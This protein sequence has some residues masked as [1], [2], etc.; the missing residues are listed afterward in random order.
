MGLFGLVYLLAIPNQNN[1]GMRS[2]SLLR[3]KC[4]IVRESNLLRRSG[5]LLCYN[6]M[7]CDLCL[8]LVLYR[9]GNM[10]RLWLSL[11]RIGRP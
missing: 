2:T 6:D 7:G 11:F 8:V 9:T 10:C 4:R 3:R 5:T 1:M